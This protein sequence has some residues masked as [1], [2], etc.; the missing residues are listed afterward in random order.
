[1]GTDQM[2]DHDGSI[3]GHNIKTSNIKQ[4][5]YL[6]DHPRTLHCIG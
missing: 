3:N 4:V 5:I 2:I 6:M 1:M